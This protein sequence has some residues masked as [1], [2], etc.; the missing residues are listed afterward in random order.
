[1]SQSPKI[2][3][4]AKA[5]VRKQTQA[6]L[7]KKKQLLNWE[8]Q[9][10]GHGMSHNTADE[11]FTESKG[12]LEELSQL[13]GCLGDASSS[14]NSKDDDSLSPFLVRLRENEIHIFQAGACISFSC[15]MKL[16][17]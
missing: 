5:G 8:K 6:T 9:A 7:E 17:R 13:T 12:S 15:E 10:E 3:A 4:A 2:Q 1:M 14:A 11:S 16:R